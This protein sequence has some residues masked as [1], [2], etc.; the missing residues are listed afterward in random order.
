MAARL[1]NIVGGALCSAL[2]IWVAAHM[3]GV[4]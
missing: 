3:I 4:L 2:I 1:A